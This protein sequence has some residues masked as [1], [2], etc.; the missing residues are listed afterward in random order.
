MTAAPAASATI[1]ELQAVL[2]SQRA[3]FRSEGAPAAEVRRHRLDRLL[4]AVLSVSKELAAAH[5]E[6]YGHRPELFNLTNIA[7]VVGPITH[8][9]DHLEQWMQPVVADAQLPTVVDSQ[10]LGT[11]GVIGPWNFPLSLVVQPTAE[12]L[13]AGNRVMIKYSDY[14]PRSGAVFTRAIARYFSPDEVAVVEGGPDVA[15]AFA[16]LPFDH[17]LFTGSPAVGRLVQAAA[18]ANLTPVT[19]ELGGKNPVVV[20]HDAD[21]TEAAHAVAAA[22]LSNGGQICLCP[23]Y[24]F[25]PSAKLEAFV[26]LARQFWL[27]ALPDYLHHEAV[28][29]IINDAN[30]DRIIGLI[31]D[32]VDKGARAVVGVTDAE[33]VHLPDRTSRRIAPHLLTGVT[34]DM[35]IASEEVFGPVLTVL[36]YDDISQVL[37]HVAR[38]PAPLAAYWL[39][40]ETDDF[41]AFRTYTNSGG[42]TRNSASPLHYSASRDLPFG[43][44]G[45]S[46]MGAYHGKAGFDT[47]SHQRVITSSLSAPTATSRIVASTP[48][49]VAA[50]RADLAAAAQDVGARLAAL[51]FE[52]REA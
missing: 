10:P 35:L 44:V 7:G 32:A 18:A 45:M 40:G 17:L 47:F 49:A 39:G 46:G 12:A 21:L 48:E 9:R 23:D 3:A 25:V 4:A 36:P 13:A 2:E 26:Q 5:D 28:T 34:D 31:D 29:T 24:V 20:A 15:A 50:T 37:N 33:A 43:G 1:D 6:D 22:R 52:P 11:V 14:A 16:S 27:D 19:L 41:R 51:G 8:A 30:F 42:I 38:R